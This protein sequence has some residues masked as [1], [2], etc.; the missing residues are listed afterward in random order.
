MELRQVLLDCWTW[1]GALRVGR[2]AAA[3]DPNAESP[4]E[5]I[6]RL[7][8][9]QHGLPTPST[10]VPIGRDR[11]DFLWPRYRTVGEADG[12][13]KYDG[14]EPDSLRHEKLRQ[15]RLEEAGL[16]VVRFT[17]RQVEH[18][19]GRTVDRFRRAFAKADAA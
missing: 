6:G 2:V 9:L 5:S 11:V 8:L 19:P 13:T 1:P 18:E 15:E 3:A 10:Q 14:S 7:L 17:W 16:T 12:M 4:L